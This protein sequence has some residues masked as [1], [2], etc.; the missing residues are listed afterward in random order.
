MTGSRIDRLCARFAAIEGGT[1]DDPASV[2]HLGVAYVVVGLLLL[3][4]PASWLLAGA[5][6][7][8]AWLHYAVAAMS[9]VVPVAAVAM[10]VRMLTAPGAV[11][12]A[13]RAA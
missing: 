7:Y 1:Y 11:A 9:A 10:G 13:V 5:P 2:R 3:G 12:A 6:A 4:I 8:Y